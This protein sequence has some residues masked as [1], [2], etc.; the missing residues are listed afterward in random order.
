[1]TTLTATKR[2]KT[3]KLADIRTNGM[4]PAIVYGAQVEN[5]II[6]VSSIDFEKIFKVAGETGTIVLELEDEKTKAKKKVDVLIH[7]VQVDPVKGF[8]KHIDFLAIDMKKLI[9]VKVPIEFIGIAPAEKDG[10]GSLVKVLHELEI[11]ALPKDIPHSIEVDLATLVV[12]DSQIHVKDISLPKD[13]E[14]ITEKDEAVALIT[15]IK[16]VIEE[17]EAVDLSEIEVEKKGKKDEEEGTEEETR[18]GEA[19]A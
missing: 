15:A 4:V 17:E 3:E 5:T 13:V 18:K 19:T 1:M 14:M 11:K 9:E 6:S 12:L 7:E 2:S 8:T 16:E 10:L